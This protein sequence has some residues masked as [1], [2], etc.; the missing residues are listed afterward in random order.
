MELY[1]KGKNGTIKFVVNVAEI[2]FYAGFDA[3]TG[4]RVQVKLQLED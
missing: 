1:L 4:L 2:S 3:G